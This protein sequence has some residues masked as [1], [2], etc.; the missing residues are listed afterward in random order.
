[1]RASHG[2]VFPVHQEEALAVV[3]VVGG[4]VVVSGQ[5]QGRVLGGRPTVRHDPELVAQGHHGQDLVDPA[6]DVEGVDAG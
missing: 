2:R 5:D 3:V 1:M 4:L 6:V